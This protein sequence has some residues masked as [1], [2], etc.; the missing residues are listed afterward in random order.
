MDAPPRAARRAAGLAVR[1][2]LVA[3]GCALSTFCYALT[4]RA[5]LGLGPLFAAQDGIAR[6]L[7]I[8][9]GTSVMLLGAFFVLLSVL[10]R[11]FPGPGTLAIPFA[12]GWL[13]DRLLP[14]LPAV[15]GLALR[16][17]VVVLATWMM[18]LGGAL[19]IAARLGPAAYDA[20]MI[21]WHRV[22]RRPIV[23][24]RLGM[25]G[26]MLLLG[27]ALGGTVGVGTI[28]TGL[29]IAPSMHTWLR[30]LSVTGAPDEPLGALAAVES[31]EA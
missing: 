29:L 8:S 21:G 31:I 14:L 26:S 27:W 12:S 18:G 10:L 20:V 24:V 28:L 1:T 25:E 16:L 5:G 11:N 3:S 17:A 9:L 4:V 6:Q 2:V 13:L 23:V 19:M 30:L 7:G 15:H 22:T